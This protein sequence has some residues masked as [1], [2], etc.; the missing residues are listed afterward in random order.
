[1][2]FHRQNFVEQSVERRNCG[3]YL[4]EEANESSSK[5]K[6]RWNRFG[7]LLCSR[8]H[9]TLSR[10][11]QL[12]RPS[13]APSYWAAPAAQRISPPPV[14]RRKCHCFRLIS[15]RLESQ[16]EGL[17]IFSRSSVLIMAI[18]SDIFFNYFHI[19]RHFQRILT[20]K[21]KKFKI[22]HH[23]MENSTLITKIIF[24]EFLNN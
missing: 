24:L 20:H 6:C 4:S 12:M 18:S 11:M 17:L 22:K 19:F 16:I 5:A 7:P 15:T 3:A 9:V 14:Q 21:F 8:S 10:Q 13:P 1:M 23:S 2:E